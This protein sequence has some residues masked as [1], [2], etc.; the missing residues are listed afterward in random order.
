[1]SMGGPSAFADS[2]YPWRVEAVQRF[3]FTERQARFLVHVLVHSGVFLERQYR[4]FSG[5]KHGHNTQTFLR[6]LTERKFATA[7][8]PGKLHT[9]RLYHVQ[10]KPLYEA[11]AEPDNRNRRAVALGRMI[12]RLMLLDVVL[13]DKN[14]TWLGTEKDKLAY[15]RSVDIFGRKL[16]DAYYP[17][18]VFGDGPRKTIRFFPDKLPIGIELGNGRSR[19]VFVYLVRQT[20]PNDFRVWLLRHG[21][22]LRGL[23]EWTVRI[24]FP[25]R[26]YKARALYLWTFRDDLTKRLSL[27]TVEEFEWYLKCRHGHDLT[28]TKAPPHGTLDETAKKFRGPRFKA[29]EHVWLNGDQTV[30]HGAASAILEEKLERG[31]G[32]PEI[33]VL[34]HQYLQLTS[35]V[36]VA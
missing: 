25:K 17:R 34:P 5:F 26:F 35:L 9:G 2:I 32:R 20:L 24:V 30:V 3:G 6:S 7:I 14:H 12:E 15:F 19:H 10:F 21:D 8:R 1:M 11:I 29:L 13:A 28:C 33:M 16:D 31:L 4:L 18:L 22:L 23:H 36:G 27:S